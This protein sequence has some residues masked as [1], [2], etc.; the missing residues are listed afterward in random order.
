MLARLIWALVLVLSLATIVLLWKSRSAYPPQERPGVGA[1]L[2][3]CAEY[4][5]RPGCR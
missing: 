4:P 1:T 2:R 3:A 5:T